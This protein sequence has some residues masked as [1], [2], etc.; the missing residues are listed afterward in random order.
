MS[1]ER[2]KDMYRAEASKNM[3]KQK[4][5]AE[6]KAEVARLRQEGECAYSEGWEIG[7]V[8]ARPG[9]I[10]PKETLLERVN[11]WNNSEA[12]ERIGGTADKGE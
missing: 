1:K 8:S 7:W 5:I 6:L 4:R 10:P 12:K 9:A 11:D 3:E 2:I